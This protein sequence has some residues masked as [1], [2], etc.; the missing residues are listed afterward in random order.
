MGPGP[1]NQIPIPGVHPRAL[2]PDNL[3]LTVVLSVFGAIVGIQLLASLGITPSTSLIGALAAMTLARIPLAMFR[4]FRSVHS[5][6]LAQTSISSATFGAANSLFLPIGIPFLFGL[7][8]MVLPMLVGVSLAMLLDAWLLYRMFDTP[9]FPPRNPWPLGIAAA[10]AI[11]AGDSG[12]KQAKLL[13]SGLATGVAGAVFA[14][15]MSASA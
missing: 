14:V 15:P 13:L 5:Q 12:G 6:N 8:D 11:K 9:A 3:I 7:P 4:G 10:E 2:A 1:E